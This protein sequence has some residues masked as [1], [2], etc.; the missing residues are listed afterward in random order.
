M[1]VRHRLSAEARLRLCRDQAVSIDVAFELFRI[2]EAFP[3]ASGAFKTTSALFDGETDN[4]D[5]EHLAF[6]HVEALK[7]F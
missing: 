3:A 5:G 4:R 6:G 2:D 1:G 7:G